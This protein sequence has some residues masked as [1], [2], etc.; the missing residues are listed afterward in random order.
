MKIVHVVGY[1]MPELGYQEYYLAKKHAV[2]G[3]DVSVISS[4]M[5][6][7]FPNIEEMLER[8]GAEPTRK[9]R[10]GVYNV[11]GFKLYRLK[12]F[13]EHNDFI[14]AGGIKRLL[15]EIKPDVVFSHESRQGLPVIPA[16][17]KKNL[18]YKYIVDQHD[19]YHSIPNYPLLKRVMRWADYN[20]FRKFIVSY[21]LKRAD[22]IIAVTE[23]T[24]KFL[25][26]KHGIRDIAMIP[27]GVDTDSF[28]F[29]SAKRQEMR[30]MYKIGADEKVLIF[31]GT[32]FPRKRLEVLIDAVKGFKNLRLLIVGDG[33][34]DYVKKL[35]NIAASNCHFTGHVPKERLK[36]Y[37]SAADIGIWP[38]NNSVIIAEAMACSLPI[39]MVD[40]QL[41]YLVNYNNGLKF[42]ENDKNGLIRC[43]TKML[44]Q[45]LKK[46]GENSRK[47]VVENYSY[48]AIA[49]KYLE[50]A[51]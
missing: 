42:E 41:G 50:L 48:S 25:M 38:G 16:L 20:L 11:D 21:N 36:E 13:F 5:A 39:V 32:I 47:A 22:R 18:K 35:K 10:A 49:K 30:D 19:F 7:P 34:K 33:E 3:H 12:H 23:Q 29:D 31:S 9:Y 2:M 43:M 51:G 37:F 14:L 26:E 44:N 40:L 1:F 4:D 17:Y 24:K 27:L 28:K 46:M 8:A 15:R 45:D 6:W